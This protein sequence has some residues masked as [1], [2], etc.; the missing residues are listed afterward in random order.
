MDLGFYHLNGR[1]VF[2]DYPERVEG[3]LSGISLRLDLSRHQFHVASIPQI[4]HSFTKH[5]IVHQLV[6]VL[7]ER[8][9]RG[10]SHLGIEV[11]IFSEPWRLTKF[12][13]AMNIGEFE[14]HFEIEL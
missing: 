9:C 6:K 2:V 14:T 5:R 10:L 3:R 7:L 12:Q 8:R 11:D 1:D 13:Y 4:F